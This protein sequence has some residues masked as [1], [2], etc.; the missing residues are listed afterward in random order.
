MKGHKDVVKILLDNSRAN[1]D[2]D[3]R[4]NIGSTAFM[5]A[6]KKGHKDVVK[7]ILDQSGGNIDFNARNDW[8]WTAFLQACIHFKTEIVQL[9]LNYAKAKEIEIPSSSCSLATELRYQGCIY[10]RR[11]VEI[12]GL[13]EKYHRLN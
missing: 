4:D 8:R 3:A 1:I 12:K 5:W 2:F 9:L 6:C 11:F 13:V 10:S 7:L